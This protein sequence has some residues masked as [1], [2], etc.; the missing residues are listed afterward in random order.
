VI[1][2]AGADSPRHQEAPHLQATTALEG[3]EELRAEATILE[4]TPERVL[5]RASTRAPG[6]LVLS[7]TYYPG[8]TAEVDGQT[9]TIQRADL[10]LRAV[11]LEP[12]E[13]RVE[14]RFQPASLRLGIWVS[15]VALVAW[16]AGMASLWGRRRKTPPAN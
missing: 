13:H 10:M 14:F 6:Y 3:A 11:Y 2:S 9:A 12:G 7:D 1:L 16:L 5:I 15:G 8:W 4:Y